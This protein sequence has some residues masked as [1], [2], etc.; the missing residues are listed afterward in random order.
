MRRVA[1]RRLVDFRNFDPTDRQQARYLRHMIE[2]VEQD[3]YAELS[4]Y[5]FQHA[6]AIATCPPGKQIDTGFIDE[7][8]DRLRARLLPWIDPEAEAKRESDQLVS[9]IREEIGYPGDPRYEAVMA[10]I[11][12]LQQHFAELD[13]KRRQAAQEYYEI[14]K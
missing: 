8:F 13:R 4:R 3:S 9:A 5:Q 2:E 12:Q 1:A 6:L 7:W 11:P 10:Q 14:M